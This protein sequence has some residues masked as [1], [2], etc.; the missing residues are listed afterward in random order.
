MLSLFVFLVEKIYFYYERITHWSVPIPIEVQEDISSVAKTDN[1]MEIIDQISF[2]GDQP[3]LYPDVRMDKVE[4]FSA[5]DGADPQL[6]AEKLKT[7]EV[8]DELTLQVSGNL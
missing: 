4:F 3:E 6:N 5:S 2:N 1:S 8:K 7:E